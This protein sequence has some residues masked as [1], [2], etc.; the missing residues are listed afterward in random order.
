[1]LWGNDITRKCCSPSDCSEHATITHQKKQ[2]NPLIISKYRLVNDK[3]LSTGGG[4]SSAV[5]IGNHCMGIFPFKCTLVGNN[6]FRAADKFL[7]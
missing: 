7:R 4:T 2:Q 3:R 5:K 6:S 1:M